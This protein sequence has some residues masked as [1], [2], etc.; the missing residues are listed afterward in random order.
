[1]G[2]AG[3]QLQPRKELGE[4]GDLCSHDGGSE[5]LE[6]GA[7]ALRGAAGCLSDR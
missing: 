4:I 2:Q 1:M 5:L 3:M 7:A 6:P